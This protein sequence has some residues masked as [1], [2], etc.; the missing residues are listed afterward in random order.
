MYLPKSASRRRQLEAEAARNNRLEIVNA[1]SQGQITRRDLLRWGIFTT[2]GTLAF[3]NGL[4]PYAPSAYAAVPTG[5]PRSPLF[6]AKKFSEPM[7]RAILPPRYDLN[8]LANNSAQWIN[9]TTNQIVNELP[10]KNWS[11]HNDYN[12]S[13]GTAYKNPATGV[14]P[15]EGRPDG[16]F[17][18][19]QRWDELFPKYGFLLSIGQVK[20][21]S[22]FNSAMPEQA[23]NAIW[24]FGARTPGMRGNIKGTRTG[25]RALRRWSSCATASPASPGSTT[26]CRSRAPRTAASAATRCRPTSTTPTTARRATAPATPTTSPARSTTT[27]GGP[28][29][30]G[31]TCRACG[32]PAIPGWMD[33]CSGPDDGDGRV[34][35]PGDFR[36]IQGSMWFHDHRFF[37][38]A[39]NVHKGMFALCNMYSAPDRGREDLNDGFNLRLPSGNALPWGNVDFDVNIAITN[40]AFK[41]DGQLFFDIFDTDG[42]L[43]DMLCVN[44]SY[45]PYMEVLPRRYRLRTLNASMARFIK[46]AL[47][48]QKASSFAA[49]TKVPFHFIAN[50]GNFVVKPL[51]MNTLDEQGMAERYDIVVDFSKFKP[52]DTHLP[53]QPA[54]ADQRSQARWRRVGGAGAGRRQRRSLRRSDPAVQGGADHAQRRR[55]VRH[56]RLLGGQRRPKRRSQRPATGVRRARRC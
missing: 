46:L 32:R 15:I 29:W 35:V 49:G 33:K 22:K 36:E 5:T 9:H 34:L 47:V 51:L 13:G 6:N 54:E 28:R 38:T 16:E 25:H 20:A 44:G 50:D 14:G 55:S 8:K 30:R 18:A 43:G 21:G 39:E 24:S 48:V 52:G 10:A 37:F 45:Y 41:P 53:R 4:S 40:P 26:T 17:F 31:A 56:L 2:A 12:A 27:T 1:L 3:K 11:Y 19:H 7:P 23:A 42:F